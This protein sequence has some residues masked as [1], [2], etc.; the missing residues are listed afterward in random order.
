MAQERPDLEDEKNRLIVEGAKNNQQLQLLENT[1]LSILSTSDNLL[2]DA[3]AIDA[4]NDSKVRAPRTRPRVMRQSAPTPPPGPPGL[5]ASQIMSNSIA[6]KQR[7]AEETENKIDAVRAGYTPVAERARVLYFCIADLA[8]VEPVYQYSLTW[9][10]NLFVAA[11]RNAAQS[12][13]LSER[14]Q[15]LSDYFTY[16]L[17]CN[18][19]RSLLEKDKML[20][21]FMLT[22]AVMKVRASQDRAG[23]DGVGWAAPRHV[24]L[25]HPRALTDDPPG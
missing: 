13:E 3:S 23:R 4:L 11:I 20:F 25:P 19:C 6:E 1:I 5:P 8:G 21:S 12:A 10:I 24:T 7:I 9:F 18:V 2:E 16:S 15:N 22:V 14:L 17:F